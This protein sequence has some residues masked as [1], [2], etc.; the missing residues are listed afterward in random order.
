MNY[1]QAGHC[2]QE[3]LSEG[4]TEP[5][6][7]V[8]PCHGLL[9]L[10]ESRETEH[11]KD[12]SARSRAVPNHETKSFREEFHWDTSTWEDSENLNS[13]EVSQASDFSKPKMPPLDFL[14]YS[15]C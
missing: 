1:C 6:Q 8:T 4:S 11:G 14:S 9:C 5:S 15:H 13:Y 7:E 3:L 2:L 12:G 10:Q